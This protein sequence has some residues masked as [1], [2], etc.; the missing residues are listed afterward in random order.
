MT[1]QAIEQIPLQFQV[2]NPMNYGWF[3]SRLPQQHIDYLW[4]IINKKKGES[5]KEHLIGNISSSYVLEDENDYF[6]LNVL[7]PLARQYHDKAGNQHPM[8]QYQR[9]LTNY[10][11]GLDSFWVNF[12]KKNE[13]NPYHDHG[14]VYSF[15]IWLRIPYEHAEQNSLPFLEGV[16]EEDRKAGMF[17]FQY[18]DIF[19]R[20][21]HHGYRLGKDVE[22][23]MLFFP[24]MFKHTVYPFYNTDETRVSV[25]G[26][27][28]LRPPTQTL[29]NT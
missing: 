22:G 20:T 29:D 23:V 13:F 9:E 1:P 3:M 17:E 16:K 6:F 21:T 12:Q 10:R 4:R 7:D 25:S 27:L 28:W 26:N 19:G 24:A 2:V 14:G 8:R 11:L 15:V 5:H 18:Y